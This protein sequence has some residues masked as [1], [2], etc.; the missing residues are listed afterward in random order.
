[1]SLLGF[2]AYLSLIPFAAQYFWQSSLTVEVYKPMSLPTHIV[3][4]GLAVFSIASVLILFSVPVFDAVGHGIPRLAVVLNFLL[5]STVWGIANGFAIAAAA[6]ADPHQQTSQWH[7]YLGAIATTIYLRS[8]L[9]PSLCGALSHSARWRVVYRCARII[10]GVT[11]AVM[12]YSLCDLI[13]DRVSALAR[14]ERWS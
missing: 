6:F 13:A 8:I 9:L 2:A 3:L 4:A 12:I 10:V 1:M 7:G 14:G 5:F 11:I